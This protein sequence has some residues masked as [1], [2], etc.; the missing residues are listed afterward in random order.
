LAKPLFTEDV[1]EIIFPVVILVKVHRPV[2]QP[3]LQD[4]VASGQKAK[5][6]HVHDD[7]FRGRLYRQFQWLELQ[8]SF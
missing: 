6:T 8:P 2:A 1:L 4:A 5:R 7:V 3:H